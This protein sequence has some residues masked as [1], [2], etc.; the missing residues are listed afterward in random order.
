MDNKDLETQLWG[1]P[2]I[3]TTSGMWDGIR[4]GNNDEA[5]GHKWFWSF[6]GKNQSKIHQIRCLGKKGYML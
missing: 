6:D 1:R 3:H 2:Q 5:N 4:A